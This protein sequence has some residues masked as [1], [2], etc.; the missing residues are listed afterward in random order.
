MCYD[1]C[2]PPIDGTPEDM[3][4]Y[5][6]WLRDEGPYAPEEQEE[7]TPAT[8]I[9]ERA[10]LE[11]F[12]DFLDEIHGAVKCGELEWDMSRVLK[13]M[14]PTAYRCG[15]NDWLDSEGLELE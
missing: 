14:D 15:F 4:D 7:D 13:E 6:M 5:D 11:R 3:A 2:G 12:D 10:A 9:T 1:L 8:T